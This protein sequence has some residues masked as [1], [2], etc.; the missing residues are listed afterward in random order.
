VTTRQNVRQRKQSITFIF[1][2]LLR[3]EN[4]PASANL[5]YGTY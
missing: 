4:G 5:S 3:H 2:N 1:N